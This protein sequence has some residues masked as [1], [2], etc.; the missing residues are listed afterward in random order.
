MLFHTLAPGN[1][2][3]STQPGYESLLARAKVDKLELQ[4][5]AGL[6]G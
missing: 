6:P 2:G 4:K 3:A 1:V 5:Q